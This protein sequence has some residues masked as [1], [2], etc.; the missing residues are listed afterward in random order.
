[1]GVD[2][3][4]LEEFAHE[5]EI[6]LNTLDEQEGPRWTLTTFATNGVEIRLRIS[7]SRVWL[8]VRTYV[9]YRVPG[10]WAEALG[11]F[12]AAPNSH[13]DN[14][15]ELR[16]QVVA[17]LP[18]R[19]RPGFLRLIRTHRRMLKLFA[20]ALPDKEQADL[21]EQLDRAFENPDPEFQ[22]PNRNYDWPFV[23]TR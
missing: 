8:D 5:S 21:D 1:M 15:A 2:S 18:S 4:E 11:P 6:S 13:Q 22:K 17:A 14:I 9:D 7:D 3:M 10:E 12:W 16:P 20:L 19:L 23:K